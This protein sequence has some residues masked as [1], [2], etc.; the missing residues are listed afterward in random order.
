VFEGVDLGRI[1]HV[2]NDTGDH[3]LQ[4][5]RD[6]SAPAPPS[7]QSWGAWVCI[8]TSKCPL[9]YRRRPT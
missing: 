5:S 8:W 4:A 2:F 7:E 1:D 3:R 6:A 9:S